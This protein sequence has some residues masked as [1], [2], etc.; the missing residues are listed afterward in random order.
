MLDTPQKFKFVADGLPDLA[1]LREDL[2]TIDQGLK[3]ALE[4][5]EKVR[6][7]TL[8]GLKVTTKELGE[9]CDKLIK[10]LLDRREKLQNQIYLKENRQQYL[11]F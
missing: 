9:Q 3:W 7:G 5:D 1:E 4:F 2:D 8:E 11:P 10:N 6:L